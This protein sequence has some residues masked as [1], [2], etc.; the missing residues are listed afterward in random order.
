M[1]L[2]QRKTQNDRETNNRGPYLYQVRIRNAHREP[3]LNEDFRYLSE[4]EEALQNASNDRI[5]IRNQGKGSLPSQNNLTTNEKNRRQKIRPVDNFNEETASGGNVSQLRQLSKSFGKSVLGDTAESLALKARAASVSIRVAS[6]MTPLYL[7]QLF[8]AILSLLAFSMAAGI[9]AIIDGSYVLSSAVR[10]ASWVGYDANSLG[11]SGGIFM[12]MY[13]LA[14]ILG[15]ISLGLALLLCKLSGFNPLSGKKSGLKQGLF[16]LAVMG[17]SLPI[18][19]LFP[20]VTL[21]LLAVW[22]YPK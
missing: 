5:F 1:A 10:A 22:K 18:S 2:P 7:A 16:L 13:G 20:W 9:S 21:L 4:G 11:V 15:L 19:N 17:Y 8:F 6:V 12:L 3:R 14:Q